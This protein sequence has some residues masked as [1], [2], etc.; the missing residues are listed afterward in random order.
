MPSLPSQAPGAKITRAGDP[1]TPCPLIITCEHAGNLV[2]SPVRPSPDDTRW[3]TTHWGYDLGAA[4]AARELARLTESPLYMAGFSRLLCDT[5][6]PWDDPACILT[7]VEGQPLAMNANLDRDERDRRRRTL[8]DP[9]HAAIDEALALRTARREPLLLLSVH[10]FTPELGQHKREM[11]LG[12]LFDDHRSLAE[13]FA[14]TLTAAGY[15]TALNAPYSGK[16]GLIY[17][18][19]QH[20]TDHGVPYLE[21][22]IRQDL[23]ANTAGVVSFVARLLGPLRELLAVIER[24]I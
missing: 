13:R 12:V 5:N 22:E 24:D 1:T 20:G 21:I 17:S 6:R 10:S 2:P 14:A 11:E 23:L 15:V 7:T 18:A 19:A 8:Y 3:L 9:Y 4:A 16:E